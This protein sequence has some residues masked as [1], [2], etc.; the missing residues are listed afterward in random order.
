MQYLT[1]EK[2]GQGVG[3]EER[4]D[5]A[6]AQLVAGFSTRKPSLVHSALSTFGELDNKLEAA[7]GRFT[8]A[9]HNHLVSLSSE[10][11]PC[12]EVELTSSVY[13]RKRGKY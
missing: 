4:Y 12:F 3:D 6:M 5:G 2:A 13:N 1:P 10:A 9:S 8:A 11:V 7:T